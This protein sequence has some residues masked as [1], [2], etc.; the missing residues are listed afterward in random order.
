MLWRDANH[1]G[2]SDNDELEFLRDIGIVSISFV[3]FEIREGEKV[4]E[5]ADVTLVQNGFI[6][7]A[8]INE[9]WFDVDFFDKIQYGEITVCAVL[10]YSHF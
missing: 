4:E 2:L 7:E 6:K 5:R 1:N 3:P 10:T 8:Y 9:F